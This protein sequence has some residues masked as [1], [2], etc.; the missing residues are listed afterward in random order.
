MKKYT[1]FTV[2]ISHEILPQFLALP[3]RIWFSA[4]LLVHNLILVLFMD[5][6]FLPR[7]IVNFF[8]EAINGTQLT[9]TKIWYS[10]II[11]ERESFPMICSEFFYDELERR[12]KLSNR[13]LKMIRKM[14]ILMIKKWSLGSHF[15]RKDG[16][17]FSW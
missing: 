14:I 5:T 6:F 3:G 1:L 2:T 12:Y 11:R 16:N 9:E 4:T 7:H 17:D 10:T 8:Q 15:S 13:E